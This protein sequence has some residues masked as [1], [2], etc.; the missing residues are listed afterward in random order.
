MSKLTLALFL[1]TIAVAGFPRTGRAT[2]Y[3]EYKKFDLS[4]PTEREPARCHV[5]L[6]ERR[7]YHHCDKWREFWRYD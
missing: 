7:N 6:K 2:N 4:S 3:H 1:T 5:H